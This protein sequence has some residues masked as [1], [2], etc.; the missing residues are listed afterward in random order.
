MKLNTNTENVVSQSKDTNDVS[1]SGPVSRTSVSSVPLTSKEECGFKSHQTYKGERG[2][3]A[4]DADLL[5]ELRAISSKSKSTDRFSNSSNDLGSET[6]ND[7]NI[8]NNKGMETKE[9]PPWKKGRGVSKIR[10]QKELPPWKKGKESVA[11]ESKTSG[12]DDSDAVI[13][14]KAGPQPTQNQTQQSKPSDGGFKSSL[15]QTFKGDRGGAAE[16]AD[17]LAELQAISSKSTKSRFTSQN[18]STDQI[19]PNTNGQLPDPRAMKSSMDTFIPVATDVADAGVCFGDHGHSFSV[20]ELV[21][22]ASL[23]SQSSKSQK[24]PADISSNISSVGLDSTESQISIDDFPGVLASKDWKLRKAAYVFLCDVLLK[25]S[26]D[27]EEGAIPS[28]SILE[29]FDDVVV[30]IVKDSNASALDAGL[31]LVNLYAIYCSEATSAVNAANITASLLNGSALSSSRPSTTKMAKALILKLMEVG[32]NVPASVHA[33]VNILLEKGLIARK[34]KVVITCSAL[35]LDTSKCFGAAYLPLSSVS[36]NMLKMLSHANAA[37]RDTGINILAEICRATGSK[38]HLKGVI[39]KLKTAQVSQLDK[40][41]E[42]QSAPLPPTVGFRCQNSQVQNDGDIVSPENV[43]KALEASKKED[44]EKR[45]AARPEVDIFSVLYNTEYAKKIQ[46]KKWS[47]KVDALK[48]LIECGGER[49]FKLIQPTPSN[50]KS[51]AELIVEMKK[52]LSHTHFAVTSKAMEVLQM[53][54][55]G[56]GEK[57]Y[58]YLRPLLLHLTSLSKDKKLTTAVA[59]CLDSLFGNVLSFEHLLDKEDAIPHALDEKKQKNALS[60]KNTLE[61]LNRC[62]KRGENAGSRGKL[63]VS[64]V[65]NLAMLLSKKLCDS[66]ASVRKASLDIFVFLLCYDDPAILEKIQMNV[67]LLKEKNP[68]AFKSL[69]KYLD[70]QSTKSDQSETAVQTDSK[71]YI[72]QKKNVTLNSQDEMAKSIGSKGDEVKPLKD[73]SKAKIHHELNNNDDNNDI[74]LVDDAINKL[75]LMKIPKWDQSDDDDGVLAGLQCKFY[76]HNIIITQ[77]FTFMIDK[78]DN[79]FL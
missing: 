28:K 36:S 66:D 5:A 15:P 49:P 64:S 74:P 29:S 42:M 45:F 27:V 76:K 48:I 11:E 13:E 62:I 30:S 46:G 39:D 14:I 53:F 51:Y 2:G 9:I 16:D 35:I 20:S 44:E 73:S 26:N 6:K 50:C 12:I 71:K 47:E 61:F 54:S 33:V 32:S 40:L 69:S 75:S 21:P 34:P 38:N 67:R 55:E 68:R 22:P 78:C 10:K 70:Q 25:R 72:S 79:I 31:E 63:T 65:Q 4:E 7:D 18:T 52:L 43:I 8:D 17:L 59:R 57:L 37:V 3:V 1:I 19:E 60:R 56:V 24:I 41:L 58:P 77:Y 23:T